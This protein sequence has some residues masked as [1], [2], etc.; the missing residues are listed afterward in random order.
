[1]ILL[2]TLD[3]LIEEKVKKGS[4]TLHQYYKE[5]LKDESF[6]KLVSLL[7]VRE[8][9]LIQNRSE[10][11]EASIEYNHCEHCK[12]L[13][14]CKNRMKGYAYM[15]IVKN[16]NLSFCYQICL[17]KKKMDEK[18]KYLENVYVYDVPKEIRE[19]SMKNIY[20]DDRN[21]FHIIK[22]LVTFIEE[23]KK[24][25]VGKGLY[26]YGNFGCGKTYLIAAM[27]NELAKNQ[28]QSAIVFWPEYL[29]DLKASF[30]T[31][32][33][34]KFEKIKKTPLLLIDD[35]GAEN[36]TVWSRD[37][38]L[39]P[40][41]QYRMSEKLP[42]FFTSNLDLDVLEKHFSVTK[43]KVDEVKAKRIIERMKQLTVKEQMISENL[44]NR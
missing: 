33:K 16:G 9:V 2:H 26:L 24:G 3:T 36:T 37:E 1:M 13:L 30:G 35:I 38:I 25:K 29:R 6:K 34:E 7:N 28:V 12:N 4:H 10:L 8:E 15:P 19:A 5:D 14:T 40:L 42:T 39:C 22:Y 17:K 20:E 23:Y 18:R 44:R 31:N 11:K 27:L 32:F 43:D 21:R 41:M